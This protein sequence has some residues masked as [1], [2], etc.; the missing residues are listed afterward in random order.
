[1]K[2][3]SKATQDQLNARQQELAAIR[4]LHLPSPRSMRVLAVATEAELRLVPRHVLEQARRMGM[5]P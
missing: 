4:A 2:I 3:M 1:M 5:L